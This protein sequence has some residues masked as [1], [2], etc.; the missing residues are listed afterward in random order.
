MAAVHLRT[1]L[2]ALALGLTAAQ[3]F[4]L[5][6]I[7]AGL[8]AHPPLSTPDAYQLRQPFLQDLDA[9]AQRPDV[10]YW[11]CYLNESNPEL[12]DYYINRTIR[13]LDEINSTVVIKGA[14]AWKF[15]SSGVVVKTPSRVFSVDVVQG[16]WKD[17]MFDDGAP[18]G[19]GHAPG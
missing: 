9:W 17:I 2:A 15:Y 12:F 6:E 7:E 10:V 16:Q 1:C 5:K 18:S 3:N 11:D 19:H 14:V 4:S 8:D 13:A